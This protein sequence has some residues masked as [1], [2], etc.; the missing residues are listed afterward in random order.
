MRLLR[1]PVR[2]L[3]G[4][5]KSDAVDP[6]E[7]K[8]RRS[9]RVPPR[10]AQDLQQRVHRHTCSRVSDVLLHAVDADESQPHARRASSTVFRYGNFVDL[11][12]ATTLQL[13]TPLTD[14]SHLSMEDAKSFANDSV[15]RLLLLH[16]IPVHVI[17]APSMALVT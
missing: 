8:A 17:V 1:G 15:Q 3:C 7:R 16:P 13:P 5:T 9:L 2:F 14:V 10:V 12:C 11:P 6:V 4:S